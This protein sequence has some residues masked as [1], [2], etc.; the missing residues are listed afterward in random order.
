MVFL[1]FFFKGWEPVKL[2][3]SYYLV[4]SYSI[5]DQPAAHSRKNY[6]IYVNKW[7]KIDIHGLNDFFRFV[8]S[9]DHRY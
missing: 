7:Y 6:Y 2:E 5:C 4:H 9:C 8:F 3:H 1:F